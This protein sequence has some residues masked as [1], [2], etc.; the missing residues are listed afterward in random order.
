MLDDL[1]LLTAEGVRMPC[2]L[3]IGCG[4]RFLK[5]GVSTGTF[6]A[7]KVSTICS[8]NLVAFSLTP[9]TL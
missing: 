7:V 9:G 1:L 3:L 6:S 2:T 8:K 4:L 5:P